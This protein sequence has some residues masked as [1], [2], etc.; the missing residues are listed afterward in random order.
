MKRYIQNV[1]STPMIVGGVFIPP[2]DGREIDEHLLPPEHQPP[3]LEAEAAPVV[4]LDA[5]LQELLAHSV[6]DV[7]A[8]LEGLSIET[9]KRLAELEA[10]GKG[11]KT[12]QEA[13]A[14]E[15]LKRA[16]AAVDGGNGEGQGEGAGT[17][18]FQE[19][20]PAGQ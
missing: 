15:L 4:D 9:V 6:A 20:Q 3:P 12:L 18:D 19:T 11:R 16:A 14:A 8:L 1:G 17:G 7:T 2:G 13:I 5:N 10:E